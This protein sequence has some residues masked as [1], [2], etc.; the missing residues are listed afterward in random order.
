MLRYAL[1]A[2]T[3][4]M[5]VTLLPAHADQLTIM[6][7]VTQATLYPQGA[8]VTRRITVD[9]APGVHDLIVPGLPL[10]TDP[11]SLRVTADGATVGAV[12]VQTDR[13][14]PA[15]TT[16]A[17]EITAAEA[18]V[19]RLEAVLRDR[20]AATAQ[21]RARA[22]AADDTVAFLRDLASGDVAPGD[23]AALA[24]TVTARILAARE[25]AV[26]A[27]AEAA[28][29]DVGR[30]DDQRALDAA[31][32]RLDAL[33][34]PDADSAALVLAVETARPG[35]VID[36]TTDTDA[37][38]WSPVY[39]LRLD[40][41]TRKLTLDRGL[42]VSQQTGEDWGAAELV[43]STARPSGQS[44]A[45]DVS[46][47]FPRIEDASAGSGGVAMER[48]YAPTAK[49][50]APAPMA[51]A[52]VEAAQMETMGAT[53]V[54]RYPA[55]VAVRS[56]ADALRLKL[57]THDLDADIMAEAVPLSDQ[58]AFLT[59]K[60]VN[61]LPD[62]ILPGPATLFS[63]GALVGQ[64]QLDLLA[65]G[66]DVRLGFGPIDGIRIERR[67]PEE[68]EGQQGFFVATNGKTETAVLRIENLTGDSWPLRVLDRV[69]VST[70]DDLKVEWTAQPEPTETDPDGERGVL[71]WTSE[72]APKQVQEISLST[73]LTWPRDQVLIP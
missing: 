60:I 63:D 53:V 14:L 31:R 22:K 64:R 44:G 23:V 30:A 68:T 33:R 25:D 9:E 36:V 32:A 48:A 26:R 47:W 19:R 50:V 17:P 29:A 3:A 59:A 12:S 65:P 4:M 56:G 6:A 18:E 62:V 2:T 5:P 20:D 66:D 41:T 38:S 24:D 16:D 51:D 35:A 15:P 13:A 21:I 39:D 67:L 42:M 11:A 72:I 69:P 10:D 37:A 45:S 70:Q 40:R 71:V 52:V 7:P 43:M 28:A 1:L 46:P 58:T 55:K 8:T 27:E 73:R 57:D 34:T 49:A 61:S 54:Y